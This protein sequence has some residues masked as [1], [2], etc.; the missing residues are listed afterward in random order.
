MDKCFFSSLKNVKNIYGFP[1]T[2]AFFFSSSD[3]LH[4]FRATFKLLSLFHCMFLQG[5]IEYTIIT[6]ILMF[7]V[8]EAQILDTRIYL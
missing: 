1:L 6:F 8:A 4:S 2:E 3:Q 5:H 7:R